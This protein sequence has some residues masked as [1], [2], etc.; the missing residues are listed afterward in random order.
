MSPQLKIDSPGFSK[1]NGK[2]GIRKNIIQHFKD[3]YK[4]GCTATPIRLDG[5]G[6]A[7]YFD[8]LVKGPGVAKLIKDK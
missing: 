2:N 1:T 4:I 7:D 6:L 8:D 5:R 3:A